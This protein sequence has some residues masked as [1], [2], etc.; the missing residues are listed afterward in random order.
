MNASFAWRPRLRAAS[1]HA[2]ASLCVALLAA[3]LV[4]GLWYPWPYRTISGGTALFGILT[5][6]DVVLGPLLTLAVFDT[7][8]RVTMLRR[9]LATV[10]LLQLAALGYGMW[11]VFLARPVVLALEGSRFRVATA[12][13]VVRDELPQAPPALRSLP[14]TGP[15]KVA[16]DVPSGGARQYDAVMRALAGVDIGMRPSFWRPWDAAA[17]HD[18]LTRSKPLAPLVAQSPAQAAE[19]DAALAR[20][21]RGVDAVRYLPLLARRTDW[22][23]LLDAGS[24]EVVGFAPLNAF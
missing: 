4:F 24:G 17:R 6:V 18:A 9:D 21:G 1:I 15:V 12:V 5:S 3:A 22:V 20:A 10:V 11:T 13:E 19:V 2:A 14:L 23:V 16:T 8:K 7:R